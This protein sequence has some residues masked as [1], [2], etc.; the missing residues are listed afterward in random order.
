M[1]IDVPPLVCLCARR[2]AR[3]GGRS[4]AP[5][6]SATA[7]A[8]RRSRID[9]LVPSVQIALGGD[10]VARCDAIDNNRD[11]AVTINELILGVNK[12]L[13]GCG[14]G[15]AGEVL[16]SPQDNELDEYDLAT[17]A[18]T[19]SGPVSPRNVNGQA[20]LLPGGGG[21]FRRRRRHRPARGATGLGRSSRPT[22][23]FLQK[24]P[25]PASP[26]ET[27]GR[28][29]DR[30]RLRCATGGCSPPH[31]QRRAAA[32]ASSSCS[33]RRPTTTAACSTNAAHARA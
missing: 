3:S 15:P 1:R 23:R 26:D 30:L 13:N 11:G 2:R 19:T 22:A 4:R 20:C 17:G 33:S 27:D 31:R 6:A 24:L 16:F 14:S 8:M 12:A 5:P 9:E 29:P 7:T 32:T 10:G 18:V 28:R 21:Q 25:L